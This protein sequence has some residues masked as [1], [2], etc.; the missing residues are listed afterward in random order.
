MKR[1]LNLFAGAAL[2]ASFA[3][4]ASAQGN[5]RGTSKLTLNGTTVSV[6]Y[7]RPSLKGRT[8]KELLA[9]LGVGEF[10]RL[11]ADKSTTFKTTGDLTFGGTKVPG[12]EYSLWAKKEAEDKWSLVFNK[13]HGQFGTEHDPSQD[14]ASVPLKM[15]TATNS[16]QQVTIKLR[17]QSGGGRVSIIWGDM[18]LSANFTAG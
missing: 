10:W 11:G 1:L 18:E 13:Q 5:P 15:E 14:L 7:G 9:K 12:G 3:V 6:E 8:S 16:A 4:A 17:K 2:A